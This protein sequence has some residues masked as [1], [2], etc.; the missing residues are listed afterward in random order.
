[1]VVFN[2]RVNPNIPMFCTNVALKPYTPTTDIRALYRTASIISAYETA[3]EEKLTVL[4]FKPE[5]WPIS[6][7]ELEFVIN[8]GSHSAEGT[9]P[10]RGMKHNAYVRLKMA[11][12][13]IKPGLMY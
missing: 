2:Q 6:G 9:W 7:N 5:R 4:F 11:I 3:V 1:M 13:S 8:S 12:Y 10:T